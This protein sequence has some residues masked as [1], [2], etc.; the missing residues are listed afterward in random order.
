MRNWKLLNKE[1]VRQIFMVSEEIADDPHN[2]FFELEG[3]LEIDGYPFMAIFFDD[4]SEFAK[5]CLRHIDDDLMGILIELQAPMLELIGAGVYLKL[6]PEECRLTA[7]LLWKYSEK[8]IIDA[9]RQSPTFEKVESLSDLNIEIDQ[10]WQ[11]TL[12]RY[13]RVYY[14]QLLMPDIEQQS[15]VLAI[16]EQQPLKGISISIYSLDG[17][18]TSYSSLNDNSAGNLYLD[19]K[20]MQDLAELFEEYSN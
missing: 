13:K 5:I 2:Y 15:Y 8:F 6:N 11:L 9:E 17:N 1:A 20:G 3:T 16:S 18:P 14:K 19:K 4:T 10:K 7:E 12:E